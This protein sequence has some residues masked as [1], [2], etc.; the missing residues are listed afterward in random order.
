MNNNV[1]FIGC[2]SL[3]IAACGGGGSATPASPVPSVPSPP[4]EPVGEIFQIETTVLKGQSTELVLQAPNVSLTNISWQQ[5]A[6]P[7]LTF[8]A[9]DSKVIG[10]TPTESGSYTFQVHYRA[11]STNESLSHSFNVNN[12]TAQLTVRLGH[13]AL[14]GSAISLISYAAED[15]SSVAI[16]KSSWRWSQLEGPT[17]SFSEANTDGSVAVF[18]DA[19]EVTQDQVL[20][21]EVSGT[22]RGQRYSD[23]IAILVENT[24]V[25]VTD[26]N[27]PFTSR[28]A[29]VFLYNPDSP[30]GQQ[31][32]DCVYSNNIRY[33]QCT[34]AQSPLIA[35][36]TTTPT[37][38]DIMDRVVVSHQWMGDQF[39]K[40]LENYDPNDD[41]KNLLRATTAIVI[42][43]DVR[44]S[45]YSPTIA[46]IYLDPSY[47]WETPEQRDTVNQAPDYRSSFGQELQF[48]IPW[49]YVKNNDYAYYSYPIRYR[50]SRTLEQ[51]NYALASL[52]YHELAHANDYFPSFR[53]LTY[54]RD[55]TVYDAVVEVYNNNQILSDYLQDNYPLD[56]LYS[57]G[58]QNELTKLAQVRFRNPDLVTDQQIAYS[59]TDVANMFKTEGAPQFYSYSST[60]E[61]LAI[62][63]DGFMMHARF[64]VSR[65]VA[66]SDQQY[67]DIVWGQR[68]RMGEE[69]IKPRVSFV[70]T[71]VLP[72][73]TGAIDFIQALP[74]PLVMDDSKTWRESVV[75]HSASSALESRG[76][77]MSTQ[78][79]KDHRLLPVE[80]IYR[81]AVDHVMT[82]PSAS[83]LP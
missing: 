54:S 58:G 62:L 26:Q 60:R 24:D 44:P 2:L 57:S 30:A 47:L 10:F 59:M 1:C 21:F 23:Q 52:L 80:G 82:Q 49:R 63:F 50:L 67:S 12:Q 29:E 34:F 27:A 77:D 14:E 42:S 9:T 48:E 73:F 7:E 45:F 69:W 3:F 8:Y 76:Q 68:D 53:W 72:E 74:P 83:K 22:V 39:K 4:P 25:L 56:P 20:Q 51:A 35:Q 33:N 5:T 75:I 36:L 66:V 15:I 70:A 38:D 37:V 13:A 17:V 41:F 6:G 43:Y 46:A 64:G 19:P 18:F 79:L 28:V 55:T 65:D 81:H 16:D 40:Y 11:G 71:R 61:D 32:V 31:L 78:H